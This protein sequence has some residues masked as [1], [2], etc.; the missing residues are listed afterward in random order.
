MNKL[1]KIVYTILYICMYKVP[2]V[3]GFVTPGQTAAVIAL[4]CIQKHIGR[5]LTIP[6]GVLLGFSPIYSIYIYF[7]YK[8]FVFIFKNIMFK[9]L[10]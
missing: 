7:K 1:Y 2:I 4:K 9:T 5:I 10:Y 3:L 6:L 8:L